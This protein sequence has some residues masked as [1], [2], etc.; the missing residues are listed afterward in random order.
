MSIT[1]IVTGILSF[2][3]SG[4]VFHA[5]F[6]ETNKR[7]IL[8]A[9]VERSRK[10]VHEHY[11]HV[12]SYDAV[13]DLINDKA[14][15][16]VV[17]N[18]PNQTHYAY[19]KQAMLAGKDVLIEKPCAGN[20][21]EV[22][23]LLEIADRQGRKCMVFQNRRWDSDFKVVQRI[24]QSGILGELIEFHVRFDR[25]RLEKSP[26]LFKEIKQ[27][28][29]G[30][31][32]DLGPHLLDQVL[33]L[34]GKPLRSIK[35]CSSHRP[36]SEV[37]DYFN[38]ILSYPN[39]F[40]VYVTGNLLVAQPLPGY[41]VHGT[42]GSLHKSRADAQELQLQGAMLPDDPNYGLEEPGQEGMLTIMNDL[43]EKQTTF[44][45]SLKGNYND[46]FN[47][48]Y[49]HIRLGK[50]YPVTAEQLLWQMELLEQEIWNS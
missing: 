43:G 38:F 39:G 3:M 10:A 24:V 23:E 26:K 22:K 1:P 50:E 48:V 16:L 14:I 8:R 31:A 18:T 30:L 37:D 36:G 47:D 46:L 21:Q 7:F 17:V 33:S 44:V 41:V 11:P 45:E 6:L 12:I 29:S 40:N 25:Y 13:D 2:G 15:E 5:P 35:I 32:Y 27:E 19:A 20:S 4:R 34:F 42:R 9:V 49:D 28:A